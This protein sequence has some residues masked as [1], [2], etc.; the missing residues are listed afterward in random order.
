MKKANQYQHEINQLKKQLHKSDL[1][2]FE[3]LQTYILSQNVFYNE[4]TINLQLLS[5]LQ[6]LIDAEKEHSDAIN[7]FGKDPQTMANEILSEL[8]S[9]KVRDRLS[10]SSLIIIM[11]WFFLLLSSNH[12]SVGMKLNLLAFILVPLLELIAIQLVFR[13]LHKSIYSKNPSRRQALLPKLAVGFIFLFCV[14]IILLINNLFSIGP[15]FVLP[16]PWNL[17]IL[18]FILIATLCYFF[19]T[20]ASRHYSRNQRS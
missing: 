20:L 14:G 13:I 6:D 17:F 18:G 5:M 10:M 3:K 12:T 9:P 7:L 1:V 4:E 11:S 16:S 15:I 2:Y 19:Y 8:P